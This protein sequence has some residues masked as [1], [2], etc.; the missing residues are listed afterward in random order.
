[1]YDLTIQP[2]KTLKAKLTL[3]VVVILTI[4]SAWFAIRWQLSEM[5]SAITRREDPNA[6]R[7]AD[8]ALRWA[9]SNPQ[10]SRFRAL[11]G[12]DAAPTD[13][14]TAVEMA[15]NT[16]R[17]APNDFRWRIE[18]ARALAQDEQ[19]ERAEDEFERAVELA[20]S[21]AAVRWAF[22]NFLMRQDRI[23]EAFAQL[24]IA[25][26]GN[27][28]Y[29]DQVFSLA[30]DYFG[31]DA[32][33][34]ESIAADNSQSRTQLAY[35]FAARGR[36]EDALRNWNY[37]NDDEKA[38]NSSFLKVM[39]QGVFEQGHF[40]VALQ[41]EK[42]LGIDEETKAEAIT[43]GSFEKILN[44]ENKSRFT[45]QVTRN[46][47]KLEIASDQNVKRTGNRS[48]RLAFRGFNRPELSNLSQV[49]VVSPQ[50]KYRLRSWVRTENL[51][52]IGT[53]MLDILNANDNK[54]I[55]RSQPFAT[56][57]NDWQ[58]IILDFTTPENCTA[59]TIRT[60]RASCGEDCPM[61]GTVWYDDFELQR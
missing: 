29:R 51:K 16:V 8:L 41:F 42:E 15:E 26:A 46:I 31:K 45:W 44:G 27:G 3:A 13:T 22:G 1:M 32:L 21:Y 20:P 35:F 24:K 50:K 59:I 57:S 58:E 28:F 12:Q 7:I 47:P 55:A 49:V 11:I 38:Q 48:V 17:L 18:L 36:A 6:V 43:N 14:R 30:W 4:V 34:L 40:P 60:I 23:D 33:Q 54:P 52:S 10:A 19:F 53:P 5:L 9:P 39:A 37:L 61:T 25:A 2:V 56:G